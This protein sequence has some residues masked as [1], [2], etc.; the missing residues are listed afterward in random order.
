MGAQIE[1]I[2][3]NDSKVVLDVEGDPDE[4][5]REF[6]GRKGPL[7]KSGEWIVTGSGVYISYAS[8]RRVRLIREAA[9]D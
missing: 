5:L 6:L 9:G 7:V 4:T 2:T 3:Q 8:V 1:C